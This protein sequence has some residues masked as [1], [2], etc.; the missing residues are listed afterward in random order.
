MTQ[1]LKG[2]SL[3]PIIYSQEVMAMIASENNDIILLA[4]KR[5]R[6]S[7]NV[8]LDMD[9]GVP[10]RISEIDAGSCVMT[11]TLTRPSVLTRLH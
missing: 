8:A 7:K 4:Y 1:S 5:C 9:I 11:R 3:F 2:F 6:G 10:F